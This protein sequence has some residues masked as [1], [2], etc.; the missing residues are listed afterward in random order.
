MG[1][2]ACWSNNHSLGHEGHC[3]FLNED[4]KTWRMD[5][6]ICHTPGGDQ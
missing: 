1:A 5:E 4:R 2:C 6:D 3:C